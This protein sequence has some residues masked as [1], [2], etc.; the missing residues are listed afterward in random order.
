MISLN[1]NCIGRLCDH[2]AVP[3]CFHDFLLK[4]IRRICDASDL[5]R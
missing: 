2:L 4:D 3:N 5:S 1:H